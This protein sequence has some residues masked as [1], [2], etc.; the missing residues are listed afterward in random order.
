M[1]KNTVDNFHAFTKLYGYVRMFHPSDEASSIDWDKFAIFGLQKVEKAADSVELRRILLELFLPVAPSTEVYETQKGL[2][3]D[4]TKII[5]QDKT[6]LTP[7]AWQRLGMSLNENQKFDAYKKARIGRLKIPKINYTEISR[8]VDASKFRGKRLSAKGI[9]CIDTDFEGYEACFFMDIYGKDGIKLERNEIYLNSDTYKEYILD[10]LVPEEAS[11][12]EIGCK[13]TAEGI[14]YISGIKLEVTNGIGR[15]GEESYSWDFENHEL[16]QPPAGWD[17]TKDSAIVEVIDYNSYKGTKCCLIDSYFEKQLFDKYPLPG[18]LI[19]KQISRELSCVVPLAL[20]SDDAGTLPHADPL[21]LENLKREF[22]GI[23]IDSLTH[24]NLY[25]RLAGVVILWNVVQHSYPY[26]DLY[27]IDWERAIDEAIESVYIC[28]SEIEYVNSLN[29]LLANLND[30][31]C[32]VEYDG[33]DKVLFSPP[34]ALAYAEGS[35]VVSH[36]IGNNSQFHLG[37][38]IMSID[39]IPVN[40]AA[41]NAAKYISSATKGWKTQIVTLKLVKGAENSS[42]NLKILRDGKNIDI[43]T[44]RCFS[45]RKLIDSRHNKGES[46]AAIE[47]LKAGIFHI[48]LS[49]AKF[50]QIEEMAEKL[51]SAKGIIFDVRYYPKLHI[52]FLGYL[53]DKPMLSQMWN[54]PQIIYPDH[55]NFVGYNTDGRWTIPPLEPRFKGKIVFLA[56]PGAISYGESLM[57]IVEEYKLGDIVGETTAGTNG[58]INP[59][60]LPG[61]YTAYYTG[62]KVL[63]HDGS[64]HHGVGIS[65]TIPCTKTIKGIAENRDE[66]LEKAIKIIELHSK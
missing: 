30:G 15:E 14:F 49:R 22:S 54:T 19:Q 61:G 33:D 34:F 17:L 2:E 41:A 55:D 59:V 7:V 21:K 11:S 3:Y 25:A 42:I 27:D 66:P 13:Q 10:V 50:A 52:G 60:K 37:D 31:H 46:P 43:E 29:L 39:G 38:V 36:V 63:K 12:L 47:E 16:N 6:G 45:Y 64:R 8:K 53:T 20:Y 28:K 65:P 51:A 35:F 24:E 56:G 62:M 58:N 44:T 5:P 1:N 18:E 4:L 40:E 23:E 32:R 48:D 9:L 57:G 26:F